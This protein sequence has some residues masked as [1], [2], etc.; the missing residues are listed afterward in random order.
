MNLFI[1]PTKSGL[2]FTFALSVRKGFNFLNEQ[3]A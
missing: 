2:T 3:T 1:I